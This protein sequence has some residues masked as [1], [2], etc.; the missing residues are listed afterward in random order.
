M[1]YHFSPIRLAKIEKVKQCMLSKLWGN[2]H[3]RIT[4]E[5]ANW[6]NPYGGKFSSMKQNIFMF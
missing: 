5:N 1:R 2:R 6:Y 4:G 3:S